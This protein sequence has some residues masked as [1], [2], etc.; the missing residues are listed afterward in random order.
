MYTNASK[1]YDT[2]GVGIT[3]LRSVDMKLKISKC[4]QIVNA[5]MVWQYKRGRNLEINYICFG[6]EI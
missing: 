3:D 6:Q 2:T 1:N 5:E 4:F